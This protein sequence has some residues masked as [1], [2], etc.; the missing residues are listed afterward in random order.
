M[1]IKSTSREGMKKMKENRGYKFY[2]FGKAIGFVLTSVLVVVVV[3]FFAAVLFAIGKI[4]FEVYFGW[5]L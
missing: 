1:E 3:G 5:M 4:S 2:Q